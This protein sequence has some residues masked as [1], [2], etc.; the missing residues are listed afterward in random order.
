LS[1]LPATGSSRSW[2]RP[3]RFESRLA[4]VGASLIA[5]AGAGALGI[6]HPLSVNLDGDPQPER[7]VPQQYCETATGDLHP[8]QPACSEDEFPRRR[9]EIEDVCQGASVRREISSVQDTVDRLRVVEADG[10]RARPEV[11]FDM[12][13]GA[14]GRLGDLRV[15]RFDDRPTC[16]APHVL[17]RYP[18]KATLGRIPRGAEGRVNFFARV[19]NYSARYR[20]REIQLA[21][22]YVD[23]NDAFC[24]PSF[25]RVT[26]FRYRTGPD[27]YVRYRTDVKRI[28]SASASSFSP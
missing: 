18:S 26:Y 20:G 24:C 8:P 11:F 25:R 9:L 6:G 10:S 22:T 28:K 1:K 16:P 19:R 7:V 21:E 2:S 13:S 5:A 27:R 15:V 23:R 4:V 3:S 12:R 14:T 17:F